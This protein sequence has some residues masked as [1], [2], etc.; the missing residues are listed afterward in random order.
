[1]LFLP[2][3]LFTFLPLK[4]LSKFFDC[5]ITNFSHNLQKSM[6]WLHTSMKPLHTIFADCPKSRNFAVPKPARHQTPPWFSIHII[7]IFEL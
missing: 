4:S 6:K 5:N 1:M 2:F 3:Y 7:I